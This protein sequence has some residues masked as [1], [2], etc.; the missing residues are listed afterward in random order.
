MDFKKE[1]SRKLLPFFVRSTP[2]GALMKITIAITTTCLLLCQASA[3]RTDIPIN[4]TRI[5]PIANNTRT[6]YFSAD[7]RATLGKD[8]ALDEREIPTI[9]PPADIFYLWTE[10]F[11]PERMWLSP[12]DIRQLRGEKYL[13]EY[14]LHVAWQGQKLLFALQSGLPAFVDSVYLIDDYS[15]WPNNFVMFK[16]ESGQQYE[17][18]NDAI[19]NF[20]VR[21]YYDGTSL[22]VRDQQVASTALTIAPNPVSS[23]VI[24]VLELSANATTLDVIDVR[25]VVCAS[26]DVTGGYAKG[27]AVGNLPS[28]AYVLVERRSNGSMRQCMFIRQ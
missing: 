9:P 14:H 10:V 13:E 3:Q 5:N 28:G 16:M 11:T 15:D 22:G 12:L 24:D 4:V 26:F 21:V 27:L 23:D 7:V 1:G 19:V 18:T 2:N 25:G 20:V 17:V 6:F 8:T